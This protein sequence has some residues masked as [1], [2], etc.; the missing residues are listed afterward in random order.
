MTTAEPDF[1]TPPVVEVALGVQ[2]QPLFGLRGINLG[3]LRDRWRAA[4]PRI[5]EQPPLPPAVE[6]GPTSSG[7]TFQLNLGSGPA[8]RYWFLSEAGTELVQLQQDR[9]IVNWREGSPPTEPYP[10]YWAL[11]QTFEERVGDLQEFL[12]NEGLGVLDVTQAEVSYINAVPVG[13]QGHG[14]LGTLLRHWGDLSTNHLGQPEQSSARLAFKVPDVGRG[15]VR[16]HVAVDPAQRPT[17]GAPV[18]FFT[19]MVRGAP[20]TGTTD[21][22]LQFMDGAHSHLLRS[23]GELTSD[24]AKEQWGRRI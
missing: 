22:A 21:A 8:A 19:L 16:M 15:P 14:N 11:R 10:R 5:E 7:L 23:F 18:L 1:A 9:L 17:D 20:L 2:F 13:E 12:A 6:S 3:P 4:Y 24:A